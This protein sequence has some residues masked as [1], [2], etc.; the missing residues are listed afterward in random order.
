VIRSPRSPRSARSA[1]RTRPDR[2]HALVPA[3]VLLVTS[4]L[5]VACAPAVGPLGTPAT[6]PATLEPSVE[7][8]SAD[9][10]PDLSSPSPTA[11]VSPSASAA[12]SGSSTPAPTPRP[13]A[14]PT[15]RPTATPSGSA[16]VRAYFVLGS[17]TDNE[18][19]A[20][21]LREIPKTQAVATA[22]M[23]ALLEGPNDAEMA[24]RPAMYTAIPD[25]TTLLGLSI[26]DGVATVDLSREFESGG[27]SASIFARLAQVVYTLTQFSTVDSVLFKL[28]GEPVTV[29][30]GEGVILDHPVGRED[31]YDQL[32]A[33]F[34]DR[35]AWGASLGN[36]GTVSGLANVFEAQFRVQL[37]DGDGD[38]LADKPVSASCGTGC[39]GS[40]RTTLAYDVP[41]AQWG[42]L[43][44]YDLSAMDGT[45]E[46]VTEY[47]VWLTPAG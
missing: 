33:I 22:A 1:R 43:R 41:A 47:R 35:P 40:F 10:T 25:G 4:A 8:P 46:N 7:V 5:V 2:T 38:T 12:P 31:Y 9:A 37:L 14:T 42:T 16:I 39:W 15:P 28:D 17:F 44:V 21:V 45:P 20:P 11:S 34:V 6:P 30:S 24:A 19:L 18:G 27:G 23:R 13:T 3:L 26:S 32:P 29:F 36:P